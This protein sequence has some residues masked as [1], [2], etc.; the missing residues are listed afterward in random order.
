MR[1]AI[2]SSY[3]ESCGNASFTKVLRDS[4]Q[5]LGHEVSPIALNL[6]L[7]QSRDPK[8]GKIGDKHI[9]QI[10]ESLKNY[11]AVNIQFEAGL[12]GVNSKQVLRRL[13]K[14]ITAGNKVVLTHHSPRILADSY[15]SVSKILKD[16][17]SMRIKKAIYSLAK[18]QTSIKRTKSNRKVFELCKANQ[19]PISSY[20]EE[21]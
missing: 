17:A 8:V 16:L 7:T 2:I 3:D 9:S 18:L 12:Y 14:L 1:I 13:E 21:S 6:N 5:D 20:V 19:T 11:D 10:A 4:L 15:E